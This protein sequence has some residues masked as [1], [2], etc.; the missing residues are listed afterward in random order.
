MSS[1]FNVLGIA[2]DGLM[3][4]QAAIDVTGQNI[5]NASTPGY[6]RR[7][8]DIQSRTTAGPS[9]GGVDVV[10]VTRNLDVFAYNRLIAEEGQ[11]GS[12]D[13]RSTALQSVQG[14]LGTSDSAIGAKLDDFYASFQTLSATPGDASA[15]AAVLAKASSLV[16][17][18]GALSGG[19]SS[20]Q[21]QLQNQAAAQANDINSKLAEV[22]TLN[23]KISQAKAIGTD[24]N[25]LR[26]RRD[27]LIRDLGA[28]IGARAVEDDKGEMTVFGA[29][30]ALVTG[31]SAASLDVSVT[32]SNSLAIRA[33]RPGG[34]VVDVTSNVVD[35]KLG[36][37]VTTREK[38]IPSVSTALDNLA[39][40]FANSVN[41]VHQSGVGLDGVSG[42][43]MFDVSSTAQGAAYT[44]R[45]SADV[46]NNPNAIAA[47]STP[48][49]LPGGSDIA[50]K[51]G[52]LSAGKLASG[53]TPS[54]T[55]ANL[56]NDLGT[57]LASATHE[58]ALRADTVAQADSLNSSTSGVSIDEETVKLTQF[59]RAFEAS[60]KVLQTVDSLL[61]GLM[62]DL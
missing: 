2:R 31:S 28:G 42:R 55:W 60:T 24:A 48:G 21:Q 20:A 26:D 10:G 17:A 37:I 5:S 23:G 4:Q 32:A 25:D 54:D 16:Q 14:L 35:G 52:Q 8:A 61:Q 29:G 9:Q 1:L 59:Q 36:G 43:S 33:T 56:T 34:S 7:D 47:A 18:F 44:L 46:A 39:F 45:L 50:V 53:N 12:A 57:R 6:V 41:A 51:L 19:L 49:D 62:Q 27:V 3:A 15:R 38:D 30:I 13:A 58:S 40:N 22:A 11:K